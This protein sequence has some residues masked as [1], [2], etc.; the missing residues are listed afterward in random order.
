MKIPG[1]SDL[2]S[3]T[4]RNP[5]SLVRRVVSLVLATIT[6]GDWPA[7]LWAMFRTF[8]W[9]IDGR[10]DLSRVKT[11]PLMAWMNYHQAE[12]L[13]KQCY[14]FGHRALKN[15]LDA[16]VYQE[17]I[18]ETQPDYILEIGNKNGGGTLFLAHM[19]DLLAKGTVL[20]LDIDH[21]AFSVT[22]PRIVTITGDCSDASIVAEVRAKVAGHRVLVIHDADHSQEAVLR[23][24]RLYAPMVSVGSYFIVED[25]IHGVSGFAINQDTRRPVFTVSNL[26]SP[27]HAAQKFL[28]GNQDFV[29]D[30]SRERYILTSNPHGFLR[31]VDPASE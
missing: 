30:K 2:P 29:L 25:T 14:W 7:R 8:R 9:R 4:G 10:Q 3:L 20:A 24:L 16:W 1:S 13:G 21:T 19:C 5:N 15:P 18:F 23:D 26:N 31:R 28:S 12:I 6:V 17:I 27:L 11:A 22:H